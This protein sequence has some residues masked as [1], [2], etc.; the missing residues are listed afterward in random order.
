MKWMSQPGNS[1]PNADSF[2]PL[3]GEEEREKRDWRSSSLSLFHQ[4]THTRA[5]RHAL[6]LSFHHT[7]TLF[8]C[9]KNTL[10]HSHRLTLSGNHL[11]TIARTTMDCNYFI[12]LFSLVY[13]QLLYHT[14]NNLIK[15][16]CCKQT[17]MMFEVWIIITLPGIKPSPQNEGIKLW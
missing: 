14:H 12:W 11:C 8:L 10:S 6:S 4:Q 1:L 17:S 15:P 2:L 5:R 7:L 16:L 13:S 3:V 9:H